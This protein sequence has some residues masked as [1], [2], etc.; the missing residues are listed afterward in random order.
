VDWPKVKTVLIV[1]LLF[2]NLVI[3][4]VFVSRLLESARL[5]REM[6]ENAVLSLER[7]GVT[8]PM[9]LLEMKTQKLYTMEVERDKE[10]EKAAYMAIIGEAEVEDLGSGILRLSGTGGIAK[11]SGDGVFEVSLSGYDRYEVPVQG[12]EA[13]LFIFKRMGVSAAEDELITYQTGNGYTVEGIQR[14]NGK[15][16][17]N[18]KY[19]MRFDDRGFYSMQGGR[20]LGKPLI[21]DATPSVSVA[22]ALLA[23]VDAMN[24][25]GTPCLEILDA[26]LG[27]FA[28]SSAPGFTQIIPV[29]QVK[30]D[31][32]TRYIN[33]VTLE[34]IRELPQ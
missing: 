27:Y 30:S 2:I 4:A 3:G 1:F 10:L 9:E 16:V 18:R 24:K 15:A 6:A 14:I 11:L 34:L 31:L 21:C 20:V 28:E 13:A 22:T 23:F 19:E 29:W 17:F 5:E 32:G 26:E 25:I 7:L 12:I 8:A 33:A